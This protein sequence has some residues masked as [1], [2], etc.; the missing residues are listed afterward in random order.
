MKDTEGSIFN[1]ENIGA[2]LVVFV[3]GCFGLWLYSNKSMNAEIDPTHSSAQKEPRSQPPLTHSHR[4][5]TANIEKQ[6]LVALP[7][8]SHAS[9]PS[10]QPTTVQN[11]TT[12]SPNNS[13]YPELQNCSASNR[14]TLLRLP[15][16]VLSELQKKTAPRLVGAHNRHDDPASPCAVQKNPLE[17]T[18]FASLRRRHNLPCT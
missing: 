16:S 6:P 18:F 1:I 13:P 11:P 10:Q 8:S 2:V 5:K 4:E 7:P 3:V 14:E 12:P 9:L 17:S 15:T